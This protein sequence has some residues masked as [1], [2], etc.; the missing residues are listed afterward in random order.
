MNSMTN[1]W[2]THKLILKDHSGSFQLGSYCRSFSFL[3]VNSSYTDGGCSNNRMLKQTVVCLTIWFGSFL[4][5]WK[6]SFELWCRPNNQT[7]DH[8]KRGLSCLFLIIHLK[9]ISVYSTCART[10]KQQCIIFSLEKHQDVKATL[11]LIEGTEQVTFLSQCKW[12]SKQFISG[13]Q[14]HLKCV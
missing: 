3:S 12:L 8:L 6:L 2:T 9:D 11:V 13:I 7:W 1:T 5:V 10:K 4:L 14:Q